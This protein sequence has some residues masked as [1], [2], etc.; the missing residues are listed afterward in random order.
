M[1]A[2]DFHV[3]C[4]TAEWLEGSIGPMLEA[5]ARYFRTEVRVR[6]VEEMAEEYRAWDLLGVLLA[7]DVETATGQPPLTNDRVAE[8]CRAYPE[9]FVG[10]ASVDPHK[11]DATEELERA[12]TELGLKGLKIH[13]QVQAFYPDEPRFEPLWEVCERHSL[14]II[15]HVGQT[16]LGAGVPGGSGIA[17]DFGRPML[18]DTV[19][20]RHPGL[21]VVMAHFGF[22]WHLEVLAS[23]M[24]KTNVWVDLSGWRPKYIPEE[25]KRD[26]RGRLSDRFV[27]GSDYPM[28][29]PGRI[30][31]EISEL[32]LGDKTDDVLKHNAA[33]LL[34][35]DLS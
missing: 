21:T 2:I 11:A 27:W 33:R 3:H 22:P 18:M 24:H 28:L 31:D 1:R 5:T 10:F 7:W 15:V 25:V 23:A 12:V 26:A 32:G 8:I 35:L 6:T 4:S 20:A 16:G 14:P 13:P 34:G 17:Y 30:L 9:Q 19:A 29:D